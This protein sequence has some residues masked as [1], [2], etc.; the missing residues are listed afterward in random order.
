MIRD[1]RGKAEYRHCTDRSPAGQHLIDGD[2]E[3]GLR[4]RALCKKILARI[5]LRSAADNLRGP[6]VKI[7]TARVSEYS[8]GIC[9]YL[10]CV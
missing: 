1:R 10:S 5:A 8:A 9:N 4:S 3:G 6:A 7:G 2:S